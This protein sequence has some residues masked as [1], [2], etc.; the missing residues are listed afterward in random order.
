MINSLRYQIKYVMQIY[1]GMFVGLAVY[2]LFMFIL[3]GGNSIIS[4]YGASVAVFVLAPIVT[5][6]SISS[7]YFSLALSAGATRKN[8]NNALQISKLIISLFQAFCIFLLAF[9]SYRGELVLFNFSILLFGVFYVL[10]S[11]GELL[12]ILAIRFGKVISVISAFLIIF[13]TVVMGM[14]IGFL[15]ARN[16]ENFVGN[17]L[18]SL[19]LGKFSIALILS[20]LAFVAVGIL[21]SVISKSLS[22]KVSL[23]N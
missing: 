19:F 2:G 1:L 17:L 13:I 23:K 6:Q 22:T 8:Y 7:L 21:I 5:V 10:V 9:F 3:S 18:L 15:T 20:S 16:G 14:S 11:I 4:I 12:G